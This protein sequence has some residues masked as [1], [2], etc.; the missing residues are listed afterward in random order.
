MNSSSSIPPDTF[1]APLPGRTFKVFMAFFHVCLVGGL[2]AALAVSCWQ[3]RGDLGW[4]QAVLAALV[5]AQIA[6]YLRSFTFLERR[7]LPGWWYPVYFLVNLAIWVGQT[8]LSPFFNWVIC[9]YFGQALA[10]L[11][12]RRSLPLAAI[13]LA[14]VV[15]VFWGWRAVAD[16]KGWQILVWGVSGISWIAVGLFI[17]HLATTS[18]ERA[19]LIVELETAKRELELARQRDAE[20]ATLRERERLARE[21][22]DN[23]GHSLVT[24]TVQL[25]AIQRLYAVDPARASALVDELKSLTRSSMEELRRSLENLRSPGLGERKLSEAIKT[26]AN[27]L[28]PRAKL[29]VDLRLPPEAD[30]L[31]PA[32][33]EALWRVAQETLTNVER[34]ARARQATMTLT[35]EP[36]GVA[37]RVHDDGV[38]LP[39]DAERRPGHFGLRGLRER[40]E[41]LGGTLT[42]S[43]E[44]NQGTVV[45]ARLPIC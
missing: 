8:R 36:K 21:L 1:H 9:C 41:G 5:V 35:L 24:L 11:P 31:Q 27:E 12:P 4:R 13:Y 45:E 6:L 23:L 10:V 43:G 42:L 38:G 15:E 34:H 7:P 26:F 19:K 30:Q 32:V 16:L 17:H 14:V 33:A 22:H 25:E 3:S 29:D 18:G 40:V 44:A 39:A 2:T 28:G 37:F 20:V